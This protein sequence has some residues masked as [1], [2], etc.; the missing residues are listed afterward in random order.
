[1]AEASNVNRRQ[2]LSAAASV[3][4]GALGIA[5]PETAKSNGARIPAPVKDLPVEGH[6]PPLKHALGWLNSPPL[7]RTDLQ[8]KVVLINF[9][10]YTCINSLRT[11][12]YLRAWAKKY[13][14]EGLVV[15]GVH[16]PEFSFEHEIDNVRRATKEIRLDYPIAIDS[17]Y[18]IWRAFE[19][20]YWPAFY[21][22]DQNGRIRHHQ[23]GE[24]EYDSTER[25]IQQ[26]LGNS[27]RADAGDELVSV[28]GLGI[29][30]AADWATVQSPESYLGTD[31]ARNFASRHKGHSYTIPSN[32]ELNHWA[33]EGNWTAGKEAAVLNETHGRIAYRFHARDLHLIMAPPSGSSVRFHVSIDGQAPGVAHG[34][35]VDGEGYGT[36]A[37]PRLYQLIRQSKSITDRT[38]EIEFLAPGAQALDFTFG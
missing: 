36:L 35:D 13:Q 31:L 7:E 30:A 1:M 19:N 33:L 20:Q 6:L 28:N 26:L 10:T 27:G 24:G 5:L 18:A 14:H 29:E 16:T 8:G 34:L 12:P 2:F 4:G 9:W 17:D 3:A 22:V 21:L 11:L 15:I 37:E 25:A 23:F 38:F 32:L